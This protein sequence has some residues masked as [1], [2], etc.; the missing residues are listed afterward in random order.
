[1][2]HSALHVLAELRHDGQGQDGD[3]GHGGPWFNHGE[4]AFLAVLLRGLQ[5]PGAGCVRVQV[6]KCCLYGGLFRGDDR[7]VTGG[8]ALL[9]V[10]MLI[11]ARTAARRLATRLCHSV[12]KPSPRNMRRP[13]P[14]GAVDIPSPFPGLSSMGEI[15]LQKMSG[16]RGPVPLA[17][18]RWRMES[19]GMGA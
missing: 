2:P 11:F 5:E 7:C 18:K 8:T 17:D 13:G 6:A 14:E 1:M 9:P 3:D 10:N 19:G 4:A 12:R 16:G 15:V